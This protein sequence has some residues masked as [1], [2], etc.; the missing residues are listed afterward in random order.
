[1]A[2]VWLLVV[3]TNDD[4]LL[5]DLPRR[6]ERSSC[7]GESTR[8]GTVSH[9]KGD[10]APAAFTEEVELSGAGQDF[11]ISIVVAHRVVVINSE[12]Y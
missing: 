2:N 4:D 6:S 9:G 3:S 12:V 10:V 5:P 11:G 7:Y 8:G 1:M